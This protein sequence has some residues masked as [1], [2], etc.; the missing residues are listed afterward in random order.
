MNKAD[1]ITLN[2][3]IMKKRQWVFI[4]SMTAMLFFGISAL[5]QYTDYQG[6]Y[7]YDDRIVIIND[8]DDHQRFRDGNRNNHRRNNRIQQERRWKER[9]LRRAY[10]IAEADGRVSRREAREIRQL[11]QEL[12]IRRSNNRNNRYRIDRR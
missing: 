2:E 9:I 1:L 5:G 7:D 6:N 10:R 12:G 11:E 4:N 3:R 8:F